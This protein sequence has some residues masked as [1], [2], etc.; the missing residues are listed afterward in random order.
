MVRLFG[1]LVYICNCING[2]FWH[3]LKVGGKLEQ[4]KVPAIFKADLKLRGEVS[5]QSGF[6][7]NGNIVI[8]NWA[9]EFAIGGFSGGN[10]PVP[11]GNINLV[12]KA[13]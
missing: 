8:E 9:S 2:I 13:L 1:L 5:S 11:S 3:E 4:E 12:V 10:F 7:L 6:P